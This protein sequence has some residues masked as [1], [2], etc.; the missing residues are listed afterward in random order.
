V[1]FK[2]NSPES[3]WSHVVKSD[4]PAECWPWTGAFFNDG[5]GTF[6]LNYRQWRAPRLAYVLTHPEFDQSLCVL[7][8]CDNP[9]CCNPAHLFAGT[10]G[11]NNTDRKRKR[12][13]NPLRGQRHQNSKLKDA[14]VLAIR[15]LYSSGDFSQ[16]RLGRMFNVSQTVISEV[17][18]RETWTHLP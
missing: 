7:H 1:L 8:R 13:S 14:D 3:F 17:I 6:K 5:Y 15:R 2:A 12:R 11:D 4:D 9:A 18:R 16:S 10:K